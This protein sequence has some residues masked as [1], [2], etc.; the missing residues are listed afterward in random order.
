VGYIVLARPIH[1]RH[2]F[3]FF[4]FFYFPSRRSFVSVCVCVCDWGARSV[5]D[6][7]WRGR[8]SGQ[9][10]SHRVALCV[11]VSHYTSHFVCVWGARLF[12][13]CVLCVAVAC[14]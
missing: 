13:V 5:R 3:F 4:I 2:L 10:V 8:W 1:R 14:V 9:V 7:L 6:S 12:C 11:C